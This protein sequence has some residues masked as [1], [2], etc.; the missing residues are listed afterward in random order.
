MVQGLSWRRDHARHLGHRQISNISGQA[1]VQPHLND[2][3]YCCLLGGLILEIWR[4]YEAMEG[5]QCRVQHNPNHT[6]RKIFNIRRTKS[7]NLSDC[8]L[9]LQLPLANP[10]KPVQVLSWE[11]RCSWSANRRCSNSIWMINTFIANSG[12]SYVNG[13]QLVRDVL[14]RASYQI[15][16][17]AGCACTGNAWN[18]FSATDFQGNLKSAIP[19]SITARASRTCHDACRDR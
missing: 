4:Y 9:V 7:P 11:W 15:R 12:T 17:I 16:K 10:L 1:M 14:P 18:V 2:Q 8:R 5:M 13:E 19:S 6:Y 3:Q